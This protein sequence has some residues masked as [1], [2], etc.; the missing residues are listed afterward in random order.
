MVSKY[1]EAFLSYQSSFL[2]FLNQSKYF[3]YL[4][5]NQTIHQS[6]ATMQKV[7]AIESLE[8]TRVHEGYFVMEFQSIVNDN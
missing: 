4:F 3:H 6:L 1:G 7:Q 8:V 2:Q 5:S